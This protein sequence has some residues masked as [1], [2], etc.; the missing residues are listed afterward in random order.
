MNVLYF[1]VFQN[2]LK[3][4][5]VVRILVRRL[6]SRAALLSYFIFTVILTSLQLS[7]LRLKNY[8]PRQLFMNAIFH[9]TDNRI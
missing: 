5:I 2:L 7:R 3:M 1:Y 6:H 4:G 8:V 9:Y